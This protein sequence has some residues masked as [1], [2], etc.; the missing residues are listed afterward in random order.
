MYLSGV[1][2]HHVRWHGCCRSAERV[3][4]GQ[5][6][7]RFGLWASRCGINLDGLYLQR[8]WPR[9]IPDVPRLIFLPPGA[10]YALVSS[11]GWSTATP[12]SWT[13]SLPSWSP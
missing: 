13:G 9:L 3:S 11:G 7:D 6:A 2:A 5:R 8:W 1:A 10:G 12:A 4:C